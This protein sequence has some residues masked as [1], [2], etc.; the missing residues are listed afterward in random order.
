ME[1]ASIKETFKIAAK[2]ED[3]AASAQKQ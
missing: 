2:L 3:E 1:F